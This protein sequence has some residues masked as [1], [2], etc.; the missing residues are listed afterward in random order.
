MDTHC[1]IDAILARLNSSD[2]TAAENP[3]TWARLVAE[4]HLGNWS[5]CLTVCCEPESYD[6]VMAL[7]DNDETGTYPCFLFVGNDIQHP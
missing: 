1:H 3:W 7:L 5:H 6:D 2:P 4:R